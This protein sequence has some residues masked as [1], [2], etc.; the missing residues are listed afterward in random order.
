MATY[1]QNQNQG[2]QRHGRPAPRPTPV[3]TYI[4]GVLAMAAIIVTAVV[5]M[6]KKKHEGMQDTPANPPPAGVA[7]PTGP[8]SPAS[9]PQPTGVAG[10]VRINFAGRFSDTGNT[11]HVELTCPSCG[12]SGL[13]TGPAAPTARRASNGRRRSSAAS[14]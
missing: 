2:G 12:K 3:G 4:G 5:V 8:G 10:D 1:Q 11:R 13:D 14:A 7:Q 6:G 9:A